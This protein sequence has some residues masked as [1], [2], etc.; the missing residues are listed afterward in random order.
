MAFSNHVTSQQTAFS[1]FNYNQT[2][3]DSAV[4]PC[5]SNSFGN[6]P[7]PSPFIS[8][9]TSSQQSV[10]HS[11]TDTEDLIFSFEE[12]SPHSSTQQRERQESL[13]TKNNIQNSDSSTDSPQPP[14]FTDLEPVIR[15]LKDNPKNESLVDLPQMI[16]DRKPY[17][18][19]L[20]D[21]MPNGGHQASRECRL[22]DSPSKLED[23]FSIP[24]IRPRIMYAGDWGEE[25]NN[26]PVS[27]SV[28]SRLSS[29]HNSP[30]THSPHSPLSAS[31]PTTRS[32]I[33]P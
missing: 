22:P 24:M 33:N 27:T 9:A 16:I 17:E 11:C 30:F 7:P 29:D 15:M 20:N 21:S 10:N 8:H 12:D 32:P 23:F 19:P 2:T 6:S 4:S 14:A 31:A 18:E 3:R 1:P 13:Q 5:S 25:K 28:P 26:S